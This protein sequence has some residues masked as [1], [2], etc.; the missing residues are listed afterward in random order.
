MREAAAWVHDR[1][2]GATPV[3]VAYPLGFDWSFLAYYF[4][5]F[6]AGSPFGHSR[7]FDLKT[8]V[9]LT[10]RVPIGR[11]GRS[12]LPPSLRGTHPHTH[13]ALDDAIE[14]AEILSALFAARAGETRAGT[15]T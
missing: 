9:A 10:T 12:S 7:A 5:V 1:S 3:L 2:R 8:A 15:P 4:A 14:Q 6:G 13:R 11:A